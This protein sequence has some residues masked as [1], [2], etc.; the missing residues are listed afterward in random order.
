MISIS[1]IK[2]DMLTLRI[3][4]KLYY[5]CPK[6][7]SFRKESLKRKS[8]N[9]IIRFEFILPMFVPYAQEPLATIAIKISID[10]PS[11]IGFAK[12]I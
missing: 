11:I 4:H 2:Y 10:E 5:V 9:R 6:D 1:L 8:N 3:L 7:N 12:R